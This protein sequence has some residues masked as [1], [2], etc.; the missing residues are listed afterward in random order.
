MTSIVI[1]VVP[2][3]YNSCQY[4]TTPFVPP[5]CSSASTRTPAHPHSLVFFFFS[6][7]PQAH[8]L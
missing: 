2:Y 6:F 3:L 1:F 5:L 7:L 8:F 4:A